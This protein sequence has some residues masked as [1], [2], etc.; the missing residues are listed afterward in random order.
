MKTLFAF[1]LTLFVTV[2]SAKITYGQSEENRT[3]I[4]MTV[5]YG[6]KNIVTD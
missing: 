3:K 4:Q 2:T 6:G 5:T 1:A